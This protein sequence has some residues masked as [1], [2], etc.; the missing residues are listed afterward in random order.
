MVVCHLFVLFCTCLCCLF[1]PFYPWSRTK[2]SLCIGILCLIYFDLMPFFKVVYAFF[3]L[4]GGLPMETIIT[5]CTYST[6]QNLGKCVQ[7]FDWY[8]TFECS[9]MYTVPLDQIKKW[10]DLKESK[11]VN[12]SA[13]YNTRLLLKYLVTVTQVRNLCR[14]NEIHTQT[15]ISVSLGDVRGIS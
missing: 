4:A 12:K 9:W 2:W 11:P 15:N 14:Y 5:G 1:F 8:C 13:M 10:I 7:T 6:S 3:T